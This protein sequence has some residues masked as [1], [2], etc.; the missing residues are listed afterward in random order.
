MVLQL[1]PDYCHYRC[2]QLP[3]EPVLQSAGLRAVSAKFIVIGAVTNL[4]FNLLLIPH[5]KSQGA[6]NASLLAE[7]TISVLYLPNS[8]GYLT[9][10]HL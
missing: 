1:E 4:V 3:G 2:Q 5:L 8:S 10:S 6:V 9:Y 7:S